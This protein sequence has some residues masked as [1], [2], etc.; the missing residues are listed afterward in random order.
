MWHLKIL[1]LPDW[2]QANHGC[3]SQVMKTMRSIKHALTERYY[4]WQ[5]AVDV[6]MAD[7]EIDMHA[8]DGQVYKP[9]AYEEDAAA[10]EN[11]AEEAKETAAGAGQEP[12]TAPKQPSL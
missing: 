3:Y 12:V 7:P 10:E 11:W 8:E 5:D 6:A 2:R 9:S 1:I 4:T